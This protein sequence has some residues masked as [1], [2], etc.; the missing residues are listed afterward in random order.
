MEWSNCTV[1]QLIEAYRERPV[2]WNSTDFYYKDRNRKED[3]WKELAEIFGTDSSK[4]NY[5]CHSCKFKS[6]IIA[7]ITLRAFFWNTVDMGI[8]KRVGKKNFKE[9]EIYFYICLGQWKKYKWQSTKST[10]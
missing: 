10:N 4:I 6:P 2:L 8:N 9:N 7:K 5:Y 1:L 3:A